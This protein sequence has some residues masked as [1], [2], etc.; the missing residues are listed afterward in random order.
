MEYIRGSETL[1]N[2]FSTDP[3]VSCDASKQVSNREMYTLC[4][5]LL[6][7]IYMGQMDFIS[8]TFVR[9]FLSKLSGKHFADHTL[10]M[11]MRISPHC[12]CILT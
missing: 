6:H 2:L 12:L 11:H 3:A 4:R 1:Y 9:F 5:I 7:F 10:H 8:S